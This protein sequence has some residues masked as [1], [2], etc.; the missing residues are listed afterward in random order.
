MLF[1]GQHFAFD[2]TFFARP[3]T[4]AIG[5]FKCEQRFVAMHDIERR[6][7]A[8]ELRR[9]LFGGYAHDAMRPFK[10]RDRDL[11]EVFGVRIELCHLQTTHDLLHGVALHVAVEERF[12]LF[13]T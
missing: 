13:F 6:E 11:A 8:L 3:G 5:S 2:I 10:A 12:F 4:N 7:R 1:G 9:E